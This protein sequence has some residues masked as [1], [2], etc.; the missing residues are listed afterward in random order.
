MKER[1]KVT[2]CHTL[3]DFELSSTGKNIRIKNSYK[4]LFTICT[5][6]IHE[7]NVLSDWLKY[8]LEHNSTLEL[9]FRTHTHTTVFE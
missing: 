6:S 3:I 7:R 1:E 2:S 8:V 5:P 4:L 9:F